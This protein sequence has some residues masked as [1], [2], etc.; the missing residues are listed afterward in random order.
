MFA[1]D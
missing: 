1:Q